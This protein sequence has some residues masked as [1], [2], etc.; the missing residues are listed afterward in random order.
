MQLLVFLV[1]H[2]LRSVCTVQQR[3]PSLQDIVTSLAASLLPLSTLPHLPFCVPL[4]YVLF[5]TSPPP[6]PPHLSSLSSSSSLLLPL[7][8]TGKI[9]QMSSF[10]E[11]SAVK[12]S[13]QSAS[14]FMLYNKR[15]LSRIYPGGARVNSSNYDPV[16]VWNCGC[17]IGVYSVND[18]M[19]RIGVYWV[20]DNCQIDVYVELS[21]V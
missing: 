7:S 20:N 6:P 17:Q 12:Y 4:S 3:S 2:L 10:G 9:H 13:I 19:C 18:N 8:H 21:S 14:R 11:G 5:P 15:Q 16:N 1:L